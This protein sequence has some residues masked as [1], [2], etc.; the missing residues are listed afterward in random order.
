MFWWQTQTGDG[1]TVG[2]TNTAAGN[3]ALHVGDDPAQVRLR[4]GALEKAMTVA[5]G[6][7][8]FMNQVHSA[9]VALVSGGTDAASAAPTAD[10]LV[11]PDGSAPL[12][13]MVADCVPVVLVGRKPGGGVVTAAAH[14]GRKGLLDGVLP[15]TVRAMRAAGA[16]GITAWIGPSVCGECYEVPEAMLEEAADLLPVLRSRTRRGTP[17]LDLPAGAEAQ[18][19]ALDVEVI[20]VPG[21][22]LESD[23]LYSHRRTSSAGRFAGVVWLS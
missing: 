23:E 12:A 3:L 5:A 7:L 20:R 21:C 2:F 6:S 9:D 10:A 1:L 4:R 15:N 11:S 22:T 17:A 18:L 8:R 19:A 13:V 14:A 16:A